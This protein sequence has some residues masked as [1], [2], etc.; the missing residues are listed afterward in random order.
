[1]LLRGCCLSKQLQQGVA[2]LKVHV[3]LNALLLAQGE[4][5]MGPAPCNRIS[6]G[7]RKTTLRPPS[8]CEVD[9]QVRSSFAA[10]CHPEPSSA[11]PFALLHFFHP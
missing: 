11:Y 6:S 5:D 1:M 10:Q 9:L 2:T 3:L 7:P 8:L 4:Q